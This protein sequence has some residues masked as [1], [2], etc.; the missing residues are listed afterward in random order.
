MTLDVSGGIL[1]GKAK[2]LSKLERVGKLHSV[3]DHLGEDEVCGAV[4]DTC[5]FVYDVGY[6]ALVHRADDRNAAADRR[7]K[8]EVNV[9]FLCESKQLCAVCRNKLLV[10]GHNALA[11]L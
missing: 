10:G 8:E 3:L 9:V 2:L 1:L 6:E 11:R 5:D 7:L 4:E